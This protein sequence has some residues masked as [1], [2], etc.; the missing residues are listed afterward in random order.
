MLLFMFLLFYRPISRLAVSIAL[1]T[2]KANFLVCA[3]GL[4]F[5]FL[6]SLLETF[7]GQQ[8]YNRQREIAASDY[9]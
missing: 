8:S 6:Q 5:L 3:N 2:V 9:V 1:A 7:L 4:C